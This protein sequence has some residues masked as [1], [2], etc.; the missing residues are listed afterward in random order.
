G[1]GKKVS[2]I[3]RY[4]EFLRAFELWITCWKT[5]NLLNC[6]KGI[7]ILSTGYRESEYS[8]P[9]PNQYWISPSKRKQYLRTLQYSSIPDFGRNFLPGNRK[10]R[11]AIFR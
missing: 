8:I 7:A 6:I 4:P 10:V 9:P 3:V 5:G 11:S 2:L 1:C